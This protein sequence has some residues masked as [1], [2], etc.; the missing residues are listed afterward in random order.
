MLVALTHILK[1]I[2]QD[3]V[4]KRLADQEAEQMREGRAYTLNE[5]IS[6]S[7]LITMGLDF[8]EKQCVVAQLPCFTSLIPFKTSSRCRCGSVGSACNRQAED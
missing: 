5:D 4:R 8:E 6:A 2:S 7:Q 1:V 3:A